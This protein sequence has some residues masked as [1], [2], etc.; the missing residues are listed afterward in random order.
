MTEVADAALEAYDAGLCVIRAAGDGTKKPLGEWKQWQEERPQ[1]AQVQ[2]WFDDEDHRG[3]GIVCGRVSGDLEMLEFEGRAVDEGVVAAFRERMQLAGIFDLWAHIA[4]GYA[5]RTPSLGWHVLYRCEQVAGNTKLARR[6]ATSIELIANPEERIKVLIETRGE[7][8]FVVVAPSRGRTHSSGRPWVLVEGG[9]ETIATISPAQRDA[10]F[11]VARGFDML[12]E[13]HELEQR[14]IPVG[15]S[16]D[17]GTLPGFDLGVDDVLEVAGFRRHHVDRNGN[18]HWTRPGKEL[19]EGS[20]LT[21]WADNGRATPWSTSIAMPS[22]FVTGRRLLTAWQ[23]HVGLNHD[24]DFT[25]AA[26]EWRREHVNVLPLDIDP[27]TGEVLKR[28]AVVIQV[29]SRPF[30]DVAIETIAC[31]LAAND[32]PSLFIRA[33]AL[34]RVRVDENGRP[35]VEPVGAYQ[36]RNRISAVSRTVRMNKDGNVSHVPPPLDIV[37]DVLATPGW[38][39]PP[40]EAVTELPTLRPDGTVHDEPGYDPVTRRLYIPNGLEVPTI[41]QRPSSDDVA[42]AGGLLLELLADFPFDTPDDRV[43]ALG[44]LLTPLMRPAIS[45]QVPL[46]LV[47]APEPGTGKGLL[48]NVAAVIATGRPAAARPLAKMDDE[49]RKMLT[50]VLI[51]GPTLVVLDNIDDAIRS[52]SL[53]A[54][55]TTDEW[56]DRLLGRTETIAVPNRCTWVATGNNI[57]VGGDIGRRCYRIRLD[58]HQARPYTRSGF[59]HPDLLGW[60]QIHRG[61]LV[62]A[63]LTICRSWWVAGR[64]A[65][66]KEPTIGGFTPW[67]HAIAGTLHHAGLGAFLANLEQLHTSLDVETESW[68]A[69]LSALHE[70]FGSRSVSASEIAHEIESEYTDL[71]YVVPAELVDAIGRPQLAKRLGEAFRR[72]DGR[73]HGA[74]EMAVVEAGLN[75][76]KTKAWTVVPLGGVQAAA[77]AGTAGTDVHSNGQQSAGTAGRRGDL[78]IQREEDFGS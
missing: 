48:A 2:Q 34:T 76:N 63:L 73:R 15:E 27:A 51:E 39:F 11:A 44:L 10:L 17:G 45:G 42:T 28:G 50:A 24:G 1:R 57:A 66:P 13:D 21:V 56:T 47:D 4:S 14:T 7:G 68:E 29:N 33:G 18:M 38:P 64:P 35:I 19:A 70:H 37:N 72:R 9:F 62:A 46:A 49:I 75:R 25:E 22:E 12:E 30:A 40:L 26:A 20:S 53:A 71:R 61:D 32:P 23:L 54:V 41:P 67:A 16:G 43:N 65:A 78:S 60:A 6:P 74:L 5:E 3:M 59:K 69:F 36:L 31:L 55:L 8:G 52:P 77:P 58:A